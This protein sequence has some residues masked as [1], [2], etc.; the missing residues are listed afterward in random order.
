M[1]RD[2]VASSPAV[3]AR[4]TRY[5][6]V[7]M[8]LIFVIYTVASADRANIGIALPYIRKEYGM[9][10][11]EAGAVISLFF[12][13]YSLGQVPFGF[14]CSRFGVRRVLPAFM[15]LTS[16]FTGLIGTA[17][18]PLAL[19]LF[20]AGLGL[21]EAPLPLSLL[22]T[23]N[24]WFPSREK[25]TA[26]G[27]FLAA[28]KL[29]SV[30]VPPVGALLIAA[31]GWRSVFY[32]CATPGA[33][34][35]LAWLTMVPDDPE[36][37][38]RVNADE[39]ALI[40]REGSSA[41]RAA[42]GAGAGRFALLDRLIRT[43]VI[44]RVATTAGLFRSPDVWACACCYLLMTGL[45]NVILAWLPTYLSTVK[46]FSLMNVGIVSSAPF[47]GGVLG[48]VL[49]GMFSDRVLERRRKPTMMVTAASTTV[50]ML[51]LIEAPN[52][53]VAVSLLLF[54]TGFMLNIGYSSFSV[55][56]MGLTTRTTYP[57]AASLVN[58]GGQA[59]GAL[60]P[61]VTGVLLDNYDWNAVFVFL[62]ACSVATLGILLGMREPLPRAEGA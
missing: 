7:V 5:R 43:R 40:K 4:P 26:T 3:V 56:S 16:L 32:V 13:T 30:I 21:V 61:F 18:G 59:G 2:S 33:L 39:A 38:G 46:H 44:T 23:I 19:K 20:R 51:L 6:W 55:Y 47:V 62:A 48:N 41:P 14:V 57:M 34:L 53:V 8:G 9:S 37:S 25:G 54:A 35:A 52:D 36:R 15:L 28:V 27:L 49:G 10:N 58:A 45:L 31:Y 60:A 42:N 1:T 50:M 12:V 24:A 11:T 17:S 22:S 29:G